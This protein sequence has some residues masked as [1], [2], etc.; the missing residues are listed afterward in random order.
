M[1]KCIICKNVTENDGET[2]NVHVVLKSPTSTE[3]VCI[4][5]ADTY[6]CNLEI[7]EYKKWC[8]KNNKKEDKKVIDKIKENIQ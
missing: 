2:I 1:M 5:C 4:D 8:K 6:F 7:E 3:H